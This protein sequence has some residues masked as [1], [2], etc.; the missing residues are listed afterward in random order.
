MKKLFVCASLAITLTAV[1]GGVIAG[2]ISGWE[3]KGS[4]NGHAIWEATRL[5]A[6]AIVNTSKGG[7]ILSRNKIRAGKK[8]DTIRVKPGQ[9]ISNC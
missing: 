4:S 1:N 7:K 5:G 9:G 2:S 8:G 6:C 3:Y